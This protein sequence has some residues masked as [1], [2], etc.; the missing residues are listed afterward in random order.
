[1][2]SAETN[3]T[4]RSRQAAVRLAPIM[5]M[6]AVSVPA[7]LVLVAARPW[8]GN[9]PL[10]YHIAVAVANLLMLFMV[11]LD[12]RL[13]GQSWPHIGLTFR[14][15]ALRTVVRTFLL[16]LAV[17]VFAIVAFVVSAIVMANIVG[18]PEGADMSSYDYL[19]G[20]L[21]LLIVALGSVY[22]TA[23]FGEEIIYRGF[24]INRIAEVGSGSRA[25]WT[26][27]V[28]I[29]SIVLGLINSDWA[30]TGIV[31][32]TFMGLAFG[33][34]YLLLGRNLWPLILAH[35]YLDTILILQ[36]YF[37]H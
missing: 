19:R 33:L 12:L 37:S 25:A 6:L 9:D 35:G 8:I 1:M 16:S 3:V 17:F 22:V 36:L 14:W 10:R 23:S 28:L 34:S 31:Q 11:W 4:S 24:L 30:L 21:P 27:A 5:G 13:R 26:L 2:T 18:I 32:M 7:L 29:S 15:A 20:N